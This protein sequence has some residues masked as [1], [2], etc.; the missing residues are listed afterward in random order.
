MIEKTLSDSTS[1][2]VFVLISIITILLASIIFL[3]YQKSKREEKWSKFEKVR[4]YTFC[5]HKGGVGKSTSAFFIMKRIASQHPETNILV[6]DASAYGDITKLCL[7]P[8]PDG[9]RQTGVKLV[10][11]K[12]TIEDCVSC[13]L[14]PPKWYEFWRKPFSFEQHFKPIKSYCPDALPNVFM[15]T[16]RFQSLNFSLESSVMTISDPE[17]SRISAQIRRDLNKSKKNWIVFIDTDGG[18]NHDFTKL[19][20]AMADSIIIPLSAGMGAHHDAYRLETILAYAESLRKRQ[21]SNA[22]VDFAFFNKLE[23]SRNQ[24]WQGS[25]FTP[26]KDVQ[27]T[28]TSVRDQFDEWQKTYPALLKAFK[29]PKDQC[30][31]ALRDGGKAFREA[32]IHPWSSKAPQDAGSAQGD[33][34]I[35]ADKIFNIVPSSRVTEVDEGEED[36]SKS[37]ASTMEAEA[38]ADESLQGEDNQ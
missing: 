13:C 24:P 10:E 20:I 18:I 2:S 17:I 30:F 25:P 8:K 16:N 4:V 26:M 31:G 1:N 35:L 34:D 3:F 32:V 27:A 33:I 9:T 5:N 6:I 11:D 29:G 21:L 19:A 36:V 7:G 38:K 28:I 22:T 14:N 23:S 37:L 15:L 12:G